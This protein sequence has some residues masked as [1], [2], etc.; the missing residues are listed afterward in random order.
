MAML[1]YEKDGSVVKLSDTRLI[2][3]KQGVE[4]V[5]SE[6]VAALQLQEADRAAREAKASMAKMEAQK[7]KDDAK[8]L[9]QLKKQML[10]DQL[11]MLTEAVRRVTERKA[12]GEVM[13]YSS[14]E[15]LPVDSRGRLR[16]GY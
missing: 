16:G 10:R 8:R 13:P 7:K 11:E 3:M 14:M 1:S 5:P 4:I 12:K 9:L 6:Q 15:G 2:D